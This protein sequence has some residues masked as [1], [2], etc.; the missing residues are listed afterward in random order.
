[1]R[2]YP[3]K[4]WTRQKRGWLIE[5]RPEKAEAEVKTALE[6]WSK[7]GF[8][9]EH[10]HAL[11]AF[12][13]VTPSFVSLGPSDVLIPARSRPYNPKRQTL[14]TAHRTNSPSAPPRESFIRV[15]G[16]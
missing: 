16:G 15:H 8:H 2:A 11:A 14:F 13:R 7:R 3:A 1:M 9:F 12:A 6:H 4:M 10:C 5:D